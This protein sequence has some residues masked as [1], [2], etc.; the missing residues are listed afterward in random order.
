MLNIP[1]R[2]SVEVD[3]ESIVEGECGDKENC[4]VSLA[5]NKYFSEEMYTKTRPISRTVTQPDPN[6][7]QDQWVVVF[8]KF[9]GDVEHY[10]EFI[11]NDDFTVWVKA[12]DEGLDVTPIRLDFD[13]DEVY[14]G[15]EEDG[16]KHINYEGVVSL[17]EEYNLQQMAVELDMV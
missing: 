11:G 13:S 8:S 17:P 7:D 1:D 10:Y 12:F 3:V 14:D 6:N 9:D 4:A 15:S 5:V 2:F 16:Y